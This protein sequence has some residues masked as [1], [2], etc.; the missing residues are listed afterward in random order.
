M[1]VVLRGVRGSIATPS[2][3]TSFYGGNTSCI[4]LRTEDGLLLVF[5]AG[6]GLRLCGE[7]LPESGT[8]HLFISHGHIDHIQGLGFFQPLHSPRWTTHIYLPAWLEDVLDNQFAHG[9]FPIPFTS[10]AGKV[11]RHGLR[12]GDV[13]RFA[14]DATVAA[15]DAPHPGGALAYK[16][17]ADGAVFLYTGDYEIVHTPEARQ[18]A[19]E[20]LDNVDLAVVDSMYSRANFRPGWGHSCWEDW[21]E[22]GCSA[23]AS[24][25]ILSHHASEMT[26]RRIDRLQREVLHYCQQNSVRLCFAREGMRFRLP[27]PAG[28][29]ASSSSATGSTVF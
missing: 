23:T 15:I 8:C 13:V 28:S 24:C 19:R 18:A 21:C 25:I 7:N 26:D 27:L 6:T 16:V 11:V 17:Q 5:D 4:E 20:M 3:A 14:N 2:P 9:M 12:A 29:A 22:L 10:F 1:E